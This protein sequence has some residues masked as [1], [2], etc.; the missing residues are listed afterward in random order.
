MSFTVYKSSAGS[1]KTFTLVKEYLKLVLG[2]D[3]ADYYRS[4]LAITFTNKA[5][6]EMK[7]RVL[8]TLESIAE[9]NLNSSQEFM[10]NLLCKELSLSREELQLRTGNVLRS[11]LHNYSDFHITTIDKFVHRIIKSFAFDLKIPMNFEVELDGQN[12]MADAV[13]VLLSQAGSEEG[14]TRVLVDFCESR[15]DDEGNWNIENDLRKYAHKLLEEDGH[16]YIEKLRHLELEDFTRI[17]KYLLE[18]VKTFE[19]KVSSIGE[20]ALHVI[21]S[22]NIPPA[23]FAGGANGICKYFEYLRD[24]RSDKFVPSTTVSKNIEQDKWTSTSCSASN[25][26]AIESIKDQLY[27]FFEK[28]NNL[29][30]TSGKLY[31]LHKMLYARIYS[32]S[33]LNEVEKVISEFRSNENRMHISEF[34][35]R[36]SEVVSKEPAP[37]IYERVGEKFRHYLIDEFQDTSELQWHNL[38]P[39][40]EN[41]LG[42]G[43]FNMIVG[44]GKQ[45]IYRFRGGEVEQF[46]RLPE[47]KNAGHD[48]L[49][50]EREQTIRRNFKE[51]VLDRNFRSKKEVIEF[52][53][54][55][56]T[57]L[58]STLPESQQS[59]YAN[60]RQ[61]PDDTKTGG[62]VMLDFLDAT[63]EEYKEDAL[64]LII[65][66]IEQCLQ[67]GYSYDDIAI[68]TRFNR[69]GSLIAEYLHAQGISV[70]SSESLVL[71]ASD[72]VRFIISNL[73]FL[74]DS[75]AGV[76]KA[77]M[78]DFLNKGSI[79]DEAIRTYS[80]Y[81]AEKF[82]SYISSLGYQFDPEDL[83]LKSLY[84]TCEEIIRIYHLDD[85]DPYVLSLLDQVLQFN[86]KQNKSNSAFLTW[87]EEKKH[88]LSID[89]SGIVN[90]VQIMSIHK[91]KGLE[92]PVVICPF[93][94]WMQGNQRDDIWSIS[95]ENEV[96]G[97]PV[98]LLPAEKKLEETAYA[99]LYKN[100]S[101][102]SALDDVNILY[103]AF[104]RPVDRLYILSSFPYKYGNLSRHFISYLESRSMYEEGRANYIIGTAT[105]AGDHKKHQ[106]KEVMHMKGYVKGPWNEVVEISRESLK[107][108]DEEQALKI[109][110]G[111]LVHQVLSEV[112]SLTEIPLKLQALYEDGM[113]SS[114]ILLELQGKIESLVK[115]T[116]LENLFGEGKQIKT[117][118]DILLPDGR[119]IRPDRVV[120]DGNTAMVIDYKTGKKRDSDRVQVDGYGDIL[121][122][123]GYSDIRK[124]LVYINE[125]ELIEL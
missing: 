51:E 29:I 95:R 59:I 16:S 110:Y 120:I 77:E 17:R 8:S 48:E 21:T 11:I 75:S 78:I 39:L 7:D 24:I 54:D 63:M 31:T 18:Q 66:H 103:V 112:N 32:I 20:D 98:F 90:A 53:N 35:K 100:E 93:M 50:K 72:K 71:P 43:H 15:A 92:F 30:R 27:A 102:K 85:Q 2:T 109:S 13:D 104:T 76:A 69:E 70:S 19:K 60:L 106:A 97:L 42:T 118:T 79:R 57:F 3:K 55:L 44:D 125:E 115:S 65:R 68:I 6:G 61:I 101:E 14:L 86:M 9:S 38:L 12:L 45:A 37:Y 96:P 111:K 117:E 121:S 82:V 41:S 33:L 87:W 84:E 83:R 47:I 28:A 74:E 56:F 34:N 107:L 52:N 25:R 114:T 108:M 122:Q 36:I 26:Q 10:L 94:N 105:R 4:I 119:F 116:Q 124:F 113:I 62:Q 99:D 49:L 58:S 123:M 40:I 46:A 80:S 1:G 22:S 5:A 64:K 23:A 67:D 89:G 91:S 73:Y 88:K 81:P